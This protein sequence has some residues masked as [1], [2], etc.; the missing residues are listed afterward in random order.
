MNIVITGFM[1]TGKT[2]ISQK[3]SKKLGWDYVDTDKIIEK[4]TNMNITDIFSKFGETHFRNLETEAAKISM[5]KDKQ[6]IATG[7]GIVLKDEN[8]DIFKTNAVIIN[9]SAKAET[10]YKRIRGSKTRPLLNKPEPLKEINRL[11]KARSR[12]Y[13]ECNY[14]VITDGL[15]VNQIVN[16]IYDYLKKNKY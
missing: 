10:I 8:M 15:N 12:F 5:E 16:K 13:K 2:T 9:L 3:L 6:V 7:G 4:N 1:G 14:R 11:L